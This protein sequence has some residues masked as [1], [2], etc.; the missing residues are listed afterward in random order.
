MDRQALSGD[1]VLVKSSQMTGRS[2]RLPWWLG[3][4]GV[5]MTENKIRWPRCLLHSLKK[6]PNNSFFKD[7]A[8]ALLKEINSALKKILPKQAE[9][10]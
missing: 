9:L 1:T 10:P 6:N 2:Q 5:K 7:P 3:G 8:K 4:G